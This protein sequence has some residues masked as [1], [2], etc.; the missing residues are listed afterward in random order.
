MVPRSS[1]SACSQPR[2]QALGDVA[3][4]LA[5]LLESLLQ[6]RRV[7]DEVA[8]LL[9]QHDALAGAQASHTEQ[10]RSASEQRE[11]RHG[12]SGDRDDA[13]GVGQRGGGHGGQ[14]SA[15]AGAT[16]RSAATRRAAGRAYL[17][18]TAR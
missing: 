13:L 15:W 12:G 8:L 10:Q 17:P 5:Q 11:D 14:A 18:K 9:A 3:D 7:G 4:V 2:V 6:G 16:R 1:S